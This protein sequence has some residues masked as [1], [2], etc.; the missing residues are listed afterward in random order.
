MSGG[1]ADG[2]NYTELLRSALLGMVEGLLRQAA[3]EGLPGEHHFY[4]TFGT[5]EGG[6]VLAPR[7]LSQHP[8][9]M[10]IV[11]Q[12]QFWNLVVEDGAFSVT[13]RFGGS[14]ERLTVP[15]RALRAFAD[16]SCGFGLRLAPEQSPDRAA[17]P[18][19][20]GVAEHSQPKERDGAAAGKV[21]DLGAFRRRS[22]NGED[23]RPA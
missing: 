12:H 23:E 17:L 6:V 8:E 21:V 4:L 18:A 22:G 16:P 19:A 3:E 1:A 5:R 20:E 2:F 9:E 14:R 7:L 13:L 11:L 15:F 10:T